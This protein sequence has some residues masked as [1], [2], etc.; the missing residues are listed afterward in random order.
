MNIMIRCSG[1]G[2]VLQTLDSKKIGFVPL[3]KYQ[4]QSLC[5]RCFRIIHYNELS[6]VSVLNNDEIIDK[7]NKTNY[8]AFFLVDLLNINDETINTYK[9]INM[10]KCM[11]ISKIDYIPKYIKFDKIKKWLKNVYH[12]ED[13]IIFFSA[14]YKKNIHVFNSI[15]EKFPSKK[16]YLLG[17]TNASKSTLVNTLLD[18]TQITTSLIPN[19]TTDFMEIKGDNGVTFIDTPGFQYKKTFY[20]DTDYKMIKK[21]NPKGF[22]KPI[23]YQLKKGMSIVIEDKI[24]IENKSEVCNVT[25]YMSNSLNFLK[26]YEKNGVLKDCE[27]KKLH[28]NPDTD[29]VFNGLGFG[30]VKNECVLNIYMENKDMIS[31]RDS[32]F[33]EVDDYE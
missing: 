20:S 1:C 3:E 24:R 30:T 15:L 31:I 17:Y 23:T 14:K 11:A 13:E 4:E 10:P 19:T 16:G 12:I 6:V 29:F 25:F 9:K 28:L 2:A 27:F 26:V 33:K 5:E 21:M 18:N 7:V 22:L 8:F 32:I